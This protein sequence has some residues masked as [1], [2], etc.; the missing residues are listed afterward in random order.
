MLEW[1]ITEQEE[2]RRLDRYLMKVFPKAPSG[3]LFKAIR[4]KAVKVNVCR[5]EPAYKLKAGDQIQIYFTQERAVQLGYGERAQEAAVPGKMPFLPIVYEDDSIIIF[6]KPA[7]L[8]SQKDTA[9]GYSLSEY[10]LDYLRQKGEYSPLDSK[11]FRPGLCNRLDRNTTGITV[12]GKTLGA[13][14]ALTQAIRLRQTEKTYLAVCLGVCPWKGARWLCHEWSKDDRS[15]Q[16]SLK[17]GKIL[18]SEPLQKPEKDQVLC[19][20]EALG[21]DLRHGWT[22]FRIRLITGKS[23]QLRAQLSSEGYPILGDHKY[24]GTAQINKYP[25]SIRNQLLHAF[26]F[27]MQ[28]APEPLQEL[29]GRLFCAP[30]PDEFRNVLKLGFSAWLQILDDQGEKNV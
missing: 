8:L 9:E 13:T 3:L 22:L 21:T 12:A 10:L 11:G 25:F 18:T 16:V 30:L 26:T 1:E 2:G 28:D 19:R 17:K 29:S 20:V 4:T 7:G 6:N 5:T 15:N 23:H 24:G 14:Q 27:C